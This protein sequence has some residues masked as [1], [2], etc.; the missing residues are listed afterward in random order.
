MVEAWRAYL[1]GHF[2]RSEQDRKLEV[3]GKV[4]EVLKELSDVMPSE[5]PKRLPP[6][7]AVN[8]YIELIPGG[9]PPAMALYWMLP[10]ELQ[11]L[12]RPFLVP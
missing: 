2:P 7:R 8:H 3:L 12:Q 4:A 6:P 5:L 10:L 1:F 11:E 9:K